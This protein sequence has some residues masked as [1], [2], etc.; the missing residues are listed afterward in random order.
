MGRE[1]ALSWLSA[2]ALAVG[3]ATSCGGDG[4]ASDVNSD[5]SA[6]T[7]ASDIGTDQLDDPLADGVVTLDEYRAGFDAF[8]ACVEEAGEVVEI[9]E[10][11][12]ASGA[13]VYGTYDTPAT[14]ACYR[15]HFLQ[16]EMT[17]QLNDPTFLAV[18]AQREAESFEAFDRSCLESV[19][20]SVPPPEV[21]AADAAIRNDL[22]GQAFDA[23]SRGD[24]PT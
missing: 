9:Y 10:R 13:V 18:Q 6:L 21:V 15:E 20:V 11:D 19:G 23:R 3:V 22:K 16:I 1:V 12:P 17:F 7:A 24:C 2:V 5:G 14:T 4:Q 8:V